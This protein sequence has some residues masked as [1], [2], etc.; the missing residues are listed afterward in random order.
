MERHDHPYNSLVGKINIRQKL[1]IMVFKPTLN[2]IS[3]WPYKRGYCIYNDG[4]AIQGSI[5]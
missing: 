1:W 2:N 5:E 3:A 4:N